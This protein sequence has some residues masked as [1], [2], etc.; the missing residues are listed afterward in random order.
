MRTRKKNGAADPQRNN[1]VDG[2]AHELA[3]N[4]KQQQQQQQHDFNNDLDHPAEA[5][6]Q[7]RQS[8]AM[9]DDEELPTSG[10]TVNIFC[11]IL[12]ILHKQRARG[13]SE[14]IC[15]LLQLV[16]DLQ[17]QKCFFFLCVFFVFVL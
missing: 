11:Y 8:Q 17:N 9:E 3:T 1:D 15:L 4:N 12:Y 14:G 16:F 10:R 7:A 6:P 5:Q 13:G 2:E